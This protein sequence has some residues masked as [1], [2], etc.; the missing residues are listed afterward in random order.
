M[1]T[2][3]HI[4]FLF[5]ALA[6]CALLFTAC[7]GPVGPTG[8]AGVNGIDGVD[9]IGI[10]TAIPEE[11]GLRGTSW[12]DSTATGTNTKTYG[13]SADGKIINITQANGVTNT[14][15]V[16][17]CTKAPEGYS[18]DSRTSWIVHYVVTSNGHSNTW[19]YHVGASDL[20]SGTGTALFVKQ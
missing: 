20:K 18:Y 2:M 6:L 17:T 1:K 15:Y 5:A 14:Y 8:P 12:T 11:S 7:E 13:F 19:V 10:L 4:A 3:K 16:I 9:Q